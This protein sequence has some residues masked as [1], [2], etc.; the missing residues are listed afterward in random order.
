MGLLEFVSLCVY[1][2]F[3]GKIAY[4]LISLDPIQVGPTMGVVVA[5]FSD[6]FLIHFNPRLVAVTKFRKKHKMILKSSS[7]FILSIFD[8]TLL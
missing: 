4:I 2:Q 3:K 1:L 6:I 8:F 7:L 5:S